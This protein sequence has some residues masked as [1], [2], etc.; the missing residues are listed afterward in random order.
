MFF[1]WLMVSY[2][3]GALPWS[4]RQGKRFYGVD[5]H[6]E[7]DGHPGVTNAFCTGG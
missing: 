3:S 6:Q 5:L 2:L 7:G 1:A 4:A